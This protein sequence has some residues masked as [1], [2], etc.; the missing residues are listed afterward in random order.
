MC[1]RVNMCISSMF[2][3]AVMSCD[4]H[5]TVGQ[6]VIIGVTS[7]SASVQTSSAVPNSSCLWGTTLNLETPS[8]QHQLFTASIY[9][10]SFQHLT[11]VDKVDAVTKRKQ[12]LTGSQPLT[13]P[14][15][16][17]ATRAICVLEQ[18]KHKVCVQNFVFLSC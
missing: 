17:M 14:F 1:S 7:H 8:L 3:C 9:P 16:N 6:C 13:D 18:A 10:P 12:T 11:A 4:S 2:L 5:C 15:S